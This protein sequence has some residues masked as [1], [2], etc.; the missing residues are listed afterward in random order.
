VQS[1]GPEPSAHIYGQ[2]RY[3]VFKDPNWNWKTFNFDAD[4]AHGDRPE[5]LITNATG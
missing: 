3:V 4:V 2:C 5:Y 1:L